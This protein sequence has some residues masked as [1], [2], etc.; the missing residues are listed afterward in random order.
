MT[1]SCAAFSNGDPKPLVTVLQKFFQSL[2]IRAFLDSSEANLRSLVELCWFEDRR[3]LSEL[4]L[5]QD[6]KKAY[7][8]GRYGFID[9]FLVS[10]PNSPNCSDA[11]IELKNVTLSSILNASA[12]SEPTH[13][14]TELL[15]Q[16]LMEETPEELL[17][18]EYRYWDQESNSHVRKSIRTLQ[19]EAIDQVNRYLQ[20]AKLGPAKGGSNG[21]YDK[22]IRYHA[23]TNSLQGYVVMWN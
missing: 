2:S 23:G 15:R 20:I 11:A 9:L 7:R 8:K 14:A 16:Q 12:G 13:A 22:R 5:A 19:Q 4:C 3:C 6:S 18:R 17:R 10:S 21:I 1:A